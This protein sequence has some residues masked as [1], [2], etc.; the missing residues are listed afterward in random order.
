MSPNSNVSKVSVWI[1]IDWI[2]FLWD[3][4]FDRFVVTAFAIS[5]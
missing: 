1:E 2:S 4:D 5:N 3:D